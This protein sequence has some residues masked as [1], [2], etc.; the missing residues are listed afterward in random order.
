MQNFVSIMLVMLSMVLAQARADVFRFVYYYPP[1]GGTET[2][3]MPVTQ[4]LERQGHTVHKE[5]FKSCHEALTYAK[6]QTNTTFVVAGGMDLLPQTAKRCP[7]LAERPGLK[8][9]T[10]IASG[11]FFVCTT[12]RRAD[13]SVKDLSAAR[14]LNLGTVST[15]TVMVPLQ[16][17]VAD[18]SPE[19]NVKVIPY[20]TQG[21]L[22]AA[23]LVGTDLDLVY[24]A[25]NVEAITGAGGKCLVSSVRNNHLDLPWLGKYGP[26]HF[27]DAY[28]TFDLWSFSQIPAGQMALLGDVFR[29]ETFKDFVSARPSFRHLGLASGANSEQQFG[30]YLGMLKSVNLQ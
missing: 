19:F 25:S 20:K 1:G 17:V 6:K 26:T 23:A 12:P 7:S 22:R 16:L 30:S 8:L 27:V 29:S 2:W 3:S 5:F 28:Q 11:A 24:M 9:V 13:L 18:K 15:D 4:E 14:T 21:E 10:N